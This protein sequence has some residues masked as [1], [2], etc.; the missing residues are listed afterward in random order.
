MFPHVFRIC[1]PFN[2]FAYQLSP[3]SIPSP[4]PKKHKY[5]V[6][7][8]T[9]LIKEENRLYVTFPGF[10]DGDWF[11][12]TD[13]VR[14]MMSLTKRSFKEPHMSLTLIFLSAS[15]VKE[16]ITYC[17]CF[18]VA[19]VTSRCNTYNFVLQDEASEAR[20]IRRLEKIPWPLLS[21][22]LPSCGIFCFCRFSLDLSNLT[23]MKWL[24][25]RLLS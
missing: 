22:F 7:P 13:H 18:F 10:F 1:S 5:N 15:S 19:V 8:E 12:M 23:E 21:Y 24:T 2:K 11:Y 9:T 20:W 16:H 25:C 14:L 4:H 6:T 3:P 17:P